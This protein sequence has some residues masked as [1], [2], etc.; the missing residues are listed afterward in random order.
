[1]AQL[2]CGDYALLD[3][4][5]TEPLR[6]TSFVLF[7]AVDGG[8]WQPIAEPVPLTPGRWSL[9]IRFVVVA[10]LF[11]VGQCPEEI[12]QNRTEETVG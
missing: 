10:I 5:V 11:T 9:T 8:Q 7:R 3:Q 1:L 12:A 2:V 6:H 4:Q